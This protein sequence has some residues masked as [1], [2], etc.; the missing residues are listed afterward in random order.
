MSEFRIKMSFTNK[1]ILITGASSGIGAHASQH[2][3]EKGARIALV[4]RNQK[5]LNEVSD[6]IMSAGSPIPLIIV[7]DGSTEAE[8]IISET[9]NHFGKLDILINNAGVQSHNTVE[10]IDLTEYDRIMNTNV[11]GVIQLTKSAIP[12]LEQT[13]GNI[14]NVSSA[15]GLRVKPNLFAYCISKAAVNQLTKSA[16]LDLAPKGIR[17][18]AINPVV[19]RTSIFETGFGMTPEQV[20]AF[21][22]SYKTL[23][24]VGHVGTT[25]DTS[26]AI[27][28]LIGDSA[29]FITGALFPIDGGA[30]TAGQ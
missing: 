12:H 4:G 6:R 29:S 13:K 9:I 20:E 24:P 2:L 3:A 1:V 23:Y 17:V 8:R 15:A 16:A 5:R 10:N 30:L 18:N 19:I 27:E 26:A 21:Y 7:A 25:A 11:R 22:D 28:F 14:L